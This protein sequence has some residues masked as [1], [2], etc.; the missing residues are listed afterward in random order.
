[1]AHFSKALLAIDKAHT[2][3]QRVLDC[4]PGLCGLNQVDGPNC[5]TPSVSSICGKFINIFTRCIN[6]NQHDILMITVADISKEQT[7]MS[8]KGE[9]QTL[10]KQSIIHRAN[11]TV[12]NV[13]LG[14]NHCIGKDRNYNSIHNTTSL[15]SYSLIR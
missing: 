15:Y 3:H 4:K 12:S 7:D 6:R 14:N 8:Y 5:P 13:I 1:M 2:V 11:C 10:T 9:L